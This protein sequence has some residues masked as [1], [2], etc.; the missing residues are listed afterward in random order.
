MHE[1]N[2]A[3]ALD[4]NEATL[5]DPLSNE[6]QLVAQPTARAPT[7]ANS[8]L[9]DPLDMQ[10]PPEQFTEGQPPLSES[11]VHKATKTYIPPVPFPKRLN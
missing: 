2:F 7:R 3:Q 4:R 8:K 1:R 10:A 9:R 5:R 11:N 6:E